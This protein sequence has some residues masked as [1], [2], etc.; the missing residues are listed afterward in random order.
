MDMEARYNALF[1]RNLFA[2]IHKNFMVK[3]KGGTDD[4]GNKWLPLSKNTKIY[5]H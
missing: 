3:S 5:N 1:L 2:I 4:L